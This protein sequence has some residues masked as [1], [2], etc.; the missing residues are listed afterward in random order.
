MYLRCRNEF[1][2]TNS[3]GTVPE[4]G[5][6]V[7]QLYIISKDIHDSAREKKTEAEAKEHFRGGVVFHILYNDICLL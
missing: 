3:N 6:R 5:I 4:L 7:L 1:P 2:I